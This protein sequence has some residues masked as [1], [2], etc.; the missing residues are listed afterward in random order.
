MFTEAI[1]LPASLLRPLVA[2]DID[3]IARHANNP[4]V[5]R[6]MRNAFPSP[7]SRSDAEWFIESPEARAQ[8]GHRFGIDVDGEAVGV[9]GLIPGDAGEVH[10]RTAEI[11]YWLG[12]PFWGHGYATEAVRGLIDAAHQTGLYSLIGARALEDN[13]LSTGGS[14]DAGE[15]YLA[16]RGRLPGVEALLKGRGLDKAA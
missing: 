3:S 13:I 2:S 1:S 12:E 7:Y 4:K 14:V 16:F 10:H 15:L 6:R 5:A 11:G 8:F 9:V